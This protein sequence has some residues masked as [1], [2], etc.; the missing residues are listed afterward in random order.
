MFNEVVSAIEKSKK[1]LICP[2]K[3]VD[4]DGL[5]SA[6]ALKLALLKIGK[7]AQVEIEQR[8]CNNRILKIIKDIETEAFEPDLIIAVDCGDVER[9]GDRAKRFTEFD[10]TVN[11]DHHGTNVGYARVNYVDGCAAAAGE[12]IFDLIKY[13]NITIDDEIASNLYVAIS[14]DTGGFAYSNTT[15]HTHSVAGELIGFNIDFPAINAY[16]FHT[17]TNREL[18]LIKEALDTLE[19]IADGKIAS[20]TVTKAVID[21]YNATDSELGGIVDYPRSIDTVIIAFYF[22]EFD[23]GVKVS[24]RSTGPDVSAIAVKY[25]GGGHIRASGCAINKPIDEVKKMLYADAVS[26]IGG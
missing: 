15:A 6:Y 13:M 14:S 11:I 7:E 3:N 2:H 16:L 10:N 26:V 21:K 12:I 18:M 1:I 19:V 20:V 25:G 17:N 8:D 24:M 23:G 5:G 4:G 22:K 9:L